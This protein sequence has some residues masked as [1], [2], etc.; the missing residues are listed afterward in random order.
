MERSDALRLLK[1]LEGADLVLLAQKHG[2]KIFH[3]KEVEGKIKRTLNKGWAGLTLERELGLPVNSRREP[4]GGSW[5]LKQVSLKRNPKTGEIKAKETMQ[6]TMFDRNHIIEHSFEES[7]VIHKIQRMVLVARLY[8][9]R[10]EK[11]SQIVMVRAADLS[12]EVGTVYEQVRRDY[13]FIRAA[14]QRGETV[15]SEMGKLI[16]S[17]TKGAGHGSTSRAWYARTQFVN[18]LLGIEK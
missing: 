10:D 11:E 9:G 17:R 18:L 7:H 3:E 6:I 13:E 5:E 2:Q 1:A 14:L 16:Q 15:R 12:L 8:A 4:N